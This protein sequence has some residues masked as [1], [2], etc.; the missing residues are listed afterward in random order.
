[1]KP[2]VEFFEGCAVELPTFTPQWLGG[3]GFGLVE[4][5]REG[6][7]VPPGF[8][9]P[10]GVHRAYL[11]QPEKVL[12]I[13]RADVSRLLNRLSTRLGYTP[14]LSVRSGAP[15]SMPG[16][17]DTVLNVGLTANTMPQWTKR[18]GETAAWDCRR[19]L[20]TMF[21]TVVRNLDK[22]RVHKFEVEACAAAKVDSVSKLSPMQVHKLCSRIEAAA[23]AVTPLTVVDQVVDAVE[24]VFCSWMGGRAV[25]YR[26]LHDISDDMG[27][28]VVVQAMVFGN[29]NERSATGVLFTRDPASGAPGVTGE[30]LVNAQGEDVVAGSHA[31]VPFRESGGKAAVVGQTVQMDKSV[32]RAL[33][34]VIAMA[35]D[36]ENGRRDM[37]DIE[38]TIED[39]KLWLLQ[40]RAGKRSATAAFR[41][42]MDLIKEGLITENEARTRVTAKQFS[43]CRR[44][45]L[46]VDKTNEAC[47]YAGRAIGASSGCAVGRVA[48]TASQVAH[49]IGEGDPVIL[50]R[51]ETT[52]DDIAMMA[53]ATGILTA[54]GGFTSHAAVVARGMDKV[55]VTGWEALGQ[56][57][58]PENFTTKKVLLVSPNSTQAVEKQ[59][60]AGD[61]VTLDGVTGDIWL[62][63]GVV[64]TGSA[65]DAEAFVARAARAAGIK[66]VG[67][68]YASLL[69][70]MEL[71]VDPLKWADLAGSMAISRPGL[72]VDLR[73][74]DELLSEVDAAFFKGLG[75]GGETQR[76]KFVTA[77]LKAATQLSKLNPAFGVRVILPTDFSNEYLMGKLNTVPM[78]HT[79]DDALTAQG[80]V[81]M[82]PRIREVLGSGAI[83]DLVMNA[84]ADK[85]VKFLSDPMTLDEAAAVLLA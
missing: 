27:T 12:S 20:V 41:I 15:V 14:L 16:M 56:E 19:R 49:Y 53:Q 70:A 50:V 37:Q 64:E 32:W 52:P 85:G 68:D 80:E 58:W 21:A 74:P 48:Y 13:I 65:A 29:M 77:Q 82:A 51:R 25:E 17:M 33:T 69:S 9:I 18:L 61:W 67:F 3:K 6:L 10:T 55:C 36:I 2:Y 11:K 39:G 44:P 83:S 66:L 30:F 42:A 31:P 62:G 81:I 4:M 26:R 43:V 72:I 57:P 71:N 84:L 79:V 40:T 34:D 23:M 54:T 78:C 46:N 47:T 59:L 8:V 75:G 22:A 76:Q 45:L 1:L 28:A 24:A 73:G 60:T 35:N 5:S 38:F 63:K 7:P